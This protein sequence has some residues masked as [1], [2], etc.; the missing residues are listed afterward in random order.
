MLRGGP[1]LASDIMSEMREIGVSQATLRRAKMKL[2]VQSRKRSG[3]RDGHFEWV[4]EGYEDG[5]IAAS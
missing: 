2:G 3:A 1:R 4:L 5:Q